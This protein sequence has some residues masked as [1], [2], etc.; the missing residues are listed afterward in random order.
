[1]LL[2]TFD[3]FI[4][5]IP[6][7]GKTKQTILKVIITNIEIFT[8]ALYFFLNHLRPVEIRAVLCKTPLTFQI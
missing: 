2:Q 7:S 8:W 6:I 5:N 3:F 1:M 4:L